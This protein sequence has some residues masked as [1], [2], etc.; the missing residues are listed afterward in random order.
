LDL[1]FEQNESN[2]LEAFAIGTS[3]AFRRTRE[4]IVGS[5]SWSEWTRLG[6]PTN[7]CIGLAVKRRSDN[8]LEAIVVGT[9]YEFFHTTQVVGFGG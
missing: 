9:D 8:S 6:R 5:G 7:R 4:E 1:S 3:H 2:Q